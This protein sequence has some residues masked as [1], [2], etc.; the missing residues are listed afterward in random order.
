MVLA[1]W[2][3]CHNDTNI[4]DGTK[5]QGSYY[6]LEVGNFDESAR[7]QISPPHEEPT[8]DPPQP[9]RDPLPTTDKTLQPDYYMLDISNFEAGELAAMTET[10]TANGL[11]KN[12]VD[13]VV[14][15]ESAPPT[16]ENIKALTEQQPPPLPKKMR[17]RSALE[18]TKIVSDKEK[19]A[20]LRRRDMTYETVTIDGGQ[21]HLSSN[22][23]KCASPIPVPESNQIQ[24]QPDSIPKLHQ[25]QTEPGFIPEQSQAEPDSILKTDQLQPE[26][27]DQTQ[28]YPDSN[29]WKR[30]STSSDPFAGLVISSSADPG[31]LSPPTGVTNDFR[32]RTE[33]I[34]DNERVEME[35]SQVHWSLSFP[36][37]QLCKPFTEC[38]GTF[39]TKSIISN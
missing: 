15:R 38:V 32:G 6:V 13:G 25:I 33:T 19:N 24:A 37:L 12:Q 2:H 30:I 10:Q 3:L 39:R 27:S 5:F 1:Q 8:R 28:T 29:S 14:H 26:E 11:E 4:A 17:S 21:A 36:M 23:P 20:S 31:S 7:I 16:Y 9:T 18:A 22:S 35:W 34:W